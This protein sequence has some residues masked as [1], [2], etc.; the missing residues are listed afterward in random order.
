MSRGDADAAVA[1]GDNLV[2]V[3]IDV[4]GFACAGLAVG[5]DAAAA[6]VRRVGIGRIQAVNVIVVNLNRAG[7]GA[8]GVVDVDDVVDVALTRLVDDLIPADFD[9]G[10]ALNVAEDDGVRRGIAGAFVSAAAVAVSAVGVFNL[11]VKDLDGLRSRAGKAV[12]VDAVTADVV[13]QIVFD[14]D[15]SGI[16][17]VKEVALGN[18][19]DVGVQ[20]VARAVFDGQLAPPTVLWMSR[21]APRMMESSIVT[22]CVVAI[23][24]VVLLAAASSQLPT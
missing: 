13:N 11:V 14:I 1:R 20:A 12:D 5:D 2:V 15:A 24:T 10:D 21:P 17:G 8:A 16:E 9:P 18:P 7:G 4:S 22:G 6:V 23:D 19:G 3:N